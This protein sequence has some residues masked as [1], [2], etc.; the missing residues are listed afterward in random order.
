MRKERVIKGRTLSTK[1]DEPIRTLRDYLQPTRKSTLS[2]MVFPVKV[3][4]FDIKP[5]L[6]QL[7]PN[8][9]GLDSESLYLHL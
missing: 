2:C 4:N 7:L 9:H 5:R 1:N 6:I 8:F 3:R